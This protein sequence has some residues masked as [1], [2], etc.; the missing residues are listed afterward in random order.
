[1]NRVIRFTL[2]TLAISALALP[3]A[4]QQADHQAASNPLVQLL[5]SKGILTA[6]EAA[7]VGTASSP[8][9]ANERLAHLLLNKGLISQEEYNAT[10]AA[11]SV[12]A[13][14]SQAAPGGAHMVN[15]AAP[16]NPAPSVKAPNP[17]AADRPNTAAWPVS[18]MMVGY[19]PG[20]GA[21]ADA[22]TIPAVAPIRVL[23]IGLPKDPKGV[24][25]DIKLGSG[26]MITPYGFFKASAVYDTTNSGGGVFGNNDF[27]LPLLLGDTGPDAG[28]QFHIKARSARAGANFAWPLSNN[29]IIL[30]AK[31]EFDWE[32]DYTTVNNRNVSSVRSSQASLRLAYARMDTKIGDVP[33]FAEF[34]QDWTLLG[35]STVMDL[36]ETTGFG[37]FFGNFYERIPQIKTGLQFTA[38]SWK[39]QPEFAI[40]L[41]AFGDANLNNSASASL[42]GSTVVGNIPTGFQDQNREGA[43]LGSASGQPGVQGRIVFDFP[44]NKGWKAVP[45]AELIVSGGHAEAQEVLPVGNIPSVVIPALTGGTAVCPANAAGNTL[46]CYFPHGLTQN[47]PQNAYSLE[48]QLPTPWVTMVAKY[49]RGSDLRYMFATQTQSAFANLAVGGALTVP[50]TT[51]LCTAGT[52]GCPAGTVTVPQN[53]WTFSGDPITFRNAYAP[54]T[55]TLTNVPVAAPYEPVRGQGGLVQLAFPLSRI[56]GAS[57]EG[58]NSGWRLFIA[59]GFDSAY[60][61]DIAATVPCTAGTTGCGAS[62]TISHSGTTGLLRSDYVPVSLRYRVNKW[63]EISNEVT[64]YDTRTGTN[65]G[66][67]GAAGAPILLTFRGTPARVNH[68]IREEF[69]TIFTF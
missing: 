64:W 69:G 49:Y 41:G 24:I 63:A 10:A 9:E 33:W 20:D 16:V 5:Q 53:I 50:G 3:V 11:S 61:R 65:A 47:I 36:F 59:Y 7:S 57:P 13:V 25:P 2:V 39:I 1:M 6:E 30:T 42:F 55:T 26:A 29:S 8:A 51:L 35:S 44:L 56:F 38:G 15:A 37:V 27:P 48:A 22:G 60:N 66:T 40:T 67:G 21:S 4:A 52:A 45:N 31:L 28:S 68:D 32:G 54:G 43:I 17:V 23:P 19:D 12:S 58:L 46:R 34:G 18:P 62:L 14:Q